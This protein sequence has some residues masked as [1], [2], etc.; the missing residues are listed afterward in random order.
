MRRRR[1]G[2]R[3]RL[4]IQ[5]KIREEPETKK[6]VPEPIQDETVILLEAAE[7][8]AMRLVDFEGMYQEEAGGQMGVSRG[9]IWRLLQSGRIK[10]IKSIL[11]GRPLLLKSDE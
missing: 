3:G 1:R 2:R 6:L 4:P 8:E 5:P 11:E 10:V 9:T 7:F